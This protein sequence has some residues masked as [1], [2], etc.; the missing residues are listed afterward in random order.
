MNKE[1]EK[2]YDSLVI[3]EWERLNVPFPRLEFEST[4]MLIKKYFPKK[5]LVCDIGCGPGRYT[6]ELLK[7][8]HKVTLASEVK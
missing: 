8:G 2:Y 3:Q 4:K 5:G 6:I 7:M 1:I